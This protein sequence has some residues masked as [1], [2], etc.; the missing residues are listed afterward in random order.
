MGE[1]PTLRIN[2]RIDN[3]TGLAHVNVAYKDGPGYWV[4]AG[5]LV[6]TPRMA[7]LLSDALAARP[8]P[9]EDPE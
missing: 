3:A 5:D 9:L 8:S 2:Q 4:R 1:G 7:A 6:M